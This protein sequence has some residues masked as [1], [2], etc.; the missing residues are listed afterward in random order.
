MQ[1]RA[2]RVRINCFWCCRDGGCSGRS[3]NRMRLMF[4][5]DTDSVTAGIWLS[6]DKTRNELN[7]PPSVDHRVTADVEQW[8]VLV[9]NPQQTSTI[10][11]LSCLIQQVVRVIWSKAASLPHTNR[12]IVFARWRQCALPSNK[13]HLGRFVV[14][15]EFTSELNTS[16]H[17]DTPTT[18]C[19]TSVAISRIDTIYTMQPSSH[20]LVQYCRRKVL[21]FG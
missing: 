8:T 15:G 2:R 19:A 13:R 21:L 6:L 12:L 11:L 4:L 16:R 18:K 14:F 10:I 5:Y 9:H 17:T 7:M 3:W 20:M 1:C